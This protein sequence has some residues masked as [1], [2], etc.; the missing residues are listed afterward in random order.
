MQTLIESAVDIGYRHFDTAF[1]YNTEV[2]LGRALKAKIKSG[3][4]TREDVFV[5]S[6]VL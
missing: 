1:F 5:T 4:I 3:I 6:K 2:P